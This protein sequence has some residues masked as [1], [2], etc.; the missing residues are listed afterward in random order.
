MVRLDSEVE[1]SEKYIGGYQEKNMKDMKEI[2]PINGGTA[3]S[4]AA[5]GRTSLNFT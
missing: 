3:A 1:P 4:C 2:C 5:L